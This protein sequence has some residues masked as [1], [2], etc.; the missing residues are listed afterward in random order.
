MIIGWNNFMGGIHLESAPEKVPSGRLL[1]AKGVHPLTLGKSRNGSA[2]LAAIDAHSLFYF[3]GQWYSGASTVC[4]RAAVSKK[5]GLS[6]SY[7][8]FA[9]M[10]PTAGKVDYLFVGDQGTNLFKL[11]STG[12]PTNWG[13]AIPGAGLTATEGAAGN[14][15]GTVRYH[16]T[17]RNTTTGHRSNSDTAYEEITVSSKIV[18]LS[19]IPVSA[20]SQV[21]QREIWRTNDGGTSFF[22][23]DTV[24]DNTTTTYN[25][26]TADSGLSSTELPT[27]NLQP[28]STFGDFYGPHN[29]SM[30]WISTV[31]GERGRL[32][33]SPIGRP[34]SVEGFIFVSSDDDP[35][36]KVIGWAG[37]LIVFTKTRIFQVLGTN[38]YTAREIYGLPGTRLPRTVVNIPGGI[39]YVA[40]DGMR[41][42]NGSRSELINYDAIGRVFR[43]ESLGGI[44]SFSPT[45]AAYARGEYIVSD[46][47]YIT[48]AVNVS[49]QRQA[50]RNLGA[51]TEALFYASEVD[52]LGATVGNKIVDFE[53]EGEDDDN[54][55][56]ISFELEPNHILLGAEKPAQVNWI[57]IDG[58]TAGDAYTLQVFLDGTLLDL[59]TVAVEGPG[60]K[61]YGSF[62]YGA[63]TYGFLSSMGVVPINRKARK[64]GVRV[65]GSVATRIEIKGIYADVEAPQEEAQGVQSG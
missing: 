8:T 18:A 49:S 52:I 45:I 55:V 10:P 38:P 56:D 5:T 34:E 6:G 58:D 20:D 29:A 13:I 41:V 4:Y 21:D 16:V 51:V 2:Q 61:L 15:D 63:E 25:D 28:Q 27:D 30:F 47:T 36:Q 37:N 42:F 65:S 48:L 50:W 43:G 1:R 17:F 23:L 19:A 24:D 39:G 60:T 26:N 46:A 3:A 54:G 59:G 9:K 35:C 44:S 64:L 32:Y 40:E 33:Y 53:K 12:A 11:D 7:L 22:L 62:K 57:Y 14:V 31:A